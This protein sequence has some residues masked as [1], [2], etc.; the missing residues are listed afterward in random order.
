M[1]WTTTT[2][3][4]SKTGETFNL[5]FVLETKTDSLV[6]EHHSWLGDDKLALMDINTENANVIQSYESWI[7]EFVS[8]YTIDGL[9]IDAAKV[10]CKSSTSMIFTDLFAYETFVLLA[11]PRNL[12]AWIL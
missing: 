7:G 3:P 2:L 9:R 12:L 4:V 1:Q 6:L 10:S 8:N 11:R 5:A